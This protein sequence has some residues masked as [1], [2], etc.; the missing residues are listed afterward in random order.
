MS[1]IKKGYKQTKVGIIPEDWEVVNFNELKDKTDS[2]SITGGPFGSDL[3]SE[4][5]TTSGV[6]VIQLQNIGDGKFI[7]KEFVYTSEEKANQLK[8]CLIY[9]N[10]IILAKMAEP[11]AR[12]CLIPS[13]EDKFLMCSDGIRLLVDKNRFSTKY[14]LEY[15]NYDLFRKIAIDRS[16]GS[17]RGR[18]GL[19]DLKT[20]PL[21]LP[22][23]KEQEKIADILITWNEAVDKQEKLIEAKELQK[24]ALMQK[25]LSGEVRFSGFTDEWEEV[26]LSKIIKLQGGYAFKSEE[27]K[28]CGV[29]IVRISNISNTSNYMEMND[30]VYYDELSND[31]NFVIKKDDLLIAMSGA[32]TGKV[33]IYNL[34]K[35]AYLNQRV[36]LFKVIKSSL[37]NYSFLTQ[38]IFSNFFSVQLTSLLVAGAQ[39]NI[40][41]KD[42]ESLKIKL[43]SLSEQQKIAEVLSLADDEINLLKNELEELK[44][45]KKALM[46]K[47]LT[48]QV[49]VKV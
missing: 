16:T 2:H 33:S 8:N 32:T 15:I 38:F 1:A 24:K 19:S 40:S 45:Q 20:I 11:V 13:F 17:T 25:L 44:L 5:Y 10:E 36:G 34:E 29:P 31:N 41:S 39:P 26:R 7:N 6:R 48:G 18:I 14:I 43:P 9:P 21:S 28:K 35:K 47:L 49:R 4:H 42:I 37:I 12:A 30:L 27:F 23:L 3:K 22:P 46:Q